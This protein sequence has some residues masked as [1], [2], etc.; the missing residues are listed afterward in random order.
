MPS[1]NKSSGAAVLLP[2][3]TSEMA[4]IQDRAVLGSASSSHAL[5]HKSSTRWREWKTCLKGVLLLPPRASTIRPASRKSRKVAADLPGVRGTHYH[6]RVCL[7]VRRAGE[8]I[9]AQLDVRRLTWLLLHSPSLPDRTVGLRVGWS[10][11]PHSHEADS[12]PKVA[13]AGGHADG[14]A[15]VLR[16]TPWPHAVPASN[17]TWT[18]TAPVPSHP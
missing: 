5:Q 2:M 8:T 14:R 13:P 18:V 16:N 7:A 15:A 9:D 11:G 10:S 4:D 1:G 17:G 3:I 6:M 12:T